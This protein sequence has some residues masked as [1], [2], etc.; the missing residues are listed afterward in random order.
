MSSS[1]AATSPPPA[2]RQSF[3]A[4][5]F[6]PQATPPS[7]AAPSK[8]PAARSRPAKRMA[9]MP[10]AASAPILSPSPAARSLPRAVLSRPAAT[11]QRAAASMAVLCM[12][13]SLSPGAPSPPLAQRPMRRA[14]GSIRQ[15]ATLKSPGAPLLP[16]ATLGPWVGPSIWIRRAMRLSSPSK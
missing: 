10:A 4:M 1:L 6:T 11:T 16:P 8:P 5:A 15:T 13:A 3:R 7:P 12:V 9:V 2:G 14:M